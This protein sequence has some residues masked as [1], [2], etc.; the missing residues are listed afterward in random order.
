MVTA[1]SQSVHEELLG[2]LAVGGRLVIPVEK[3]GQQRL[4]VIKRT[5]D[6]FSETDLGAVIFVPLLSG[7]LANGTS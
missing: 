1:A 7:L 5:E 6:G 3:K 2:Q 4:M